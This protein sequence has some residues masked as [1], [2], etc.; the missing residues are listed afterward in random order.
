MEA[1]EFPKALLR[2]FVLGFGWTL[3]AIFCLAGSLVV[4]MLFAKILQRFVS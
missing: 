1:S 3:T 4:L 2:A